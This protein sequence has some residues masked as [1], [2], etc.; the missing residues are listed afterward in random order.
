LSAYW[1][2]AGISYKQ[3]EINLTIAPRIDANTATIIQVPI[4]ILTPT[5]DIGSYAVELFAYS[6]VGNSNVGASAYS[7]Q[8]AGIG[9]GEGGGASL[10]LIKNIGRSAYVDGATGT[11]AV[12]DGANNTLSFP[13]AIIGNSSRYSIKFDLSSTGCLPTTY[14]YNSTK[15]DITSQA[16][17]TNYIKGLTQSDWDGY[18][19]F[20]KPSVPLTQVSGFV[21]NVPVTINTLNAGGTGTVPTSGWEYTMSIPVEL[22][23]LGDPILVIRPGSVSINSGYTL[24]TILSGIAYY[25]QAAVDVAPYSFIIT[26]FYNTAL[27][28]D[29]IFAEFTG[30]ASLTMTANFNLLYTTTPDVPTAPFAQYQPLIGKPVRGTGSCPYTD[31]Q[32]IEEPCSYVGCEIGDWKA[33]SPCYG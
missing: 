18:N 11:T 5:Y 27:I 32:E 25:T 33:W 16:G 14:T 29:L 23:N 28:P 3:N 31:G 26:N 1:K 9:G 13:M 12:F 8:L 20:L 21:G 19:F 4:Q 7:V 22:D 30:G 17:Y 15:L 24:T 10:D 2:I 6:N